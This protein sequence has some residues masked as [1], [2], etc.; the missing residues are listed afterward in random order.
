MTENNKKMKRSI[1][2][3]RRIAAA[4]ALLLLLSGLTSCTDNGDHALPAPRHSHTVELALKLSVS[5]ETD[6]TPSESGLSTGTRAVDDPDTA[7]WSTVKNVWILQFD[8]QDDSALLTGTPAYI[9]GY[10]T[11][12]DYERVCTLVNGTG[13]TVWI[14]AN[15]FDKDRIWSTDLTLGQLKTYHIQVDA[16]ADLHGRGEAVDID[17]GYPGDYDYHLLMNGTYTGNIDAGAELQCTL[18]RNAVRLD[19]CLKNLS[20][21]ITVDSVKLHRVIQR[22]FLYNS[23]ALPTVFPIGGQ[24]AVRDFEPVAFNKGADLGNGYTRFRFYLT[25]N[26]RGVNANVNDVWDRNRLAPAGATAIRVYARQTDGATAT[27]LT[28]TYYPGANLTT[29]FNLCPDHSYTCNAVIN[30]DPTDPHMQ[31][32]DIR[33][34]AAPGEERANCYMLNPNPAG[35]RQFRIPVDRINLFWGGRGYENAPGNVIHAADEWTAGVVWADFTPQDTDPAG[36]DYFRLVKPSGKGSEGNIDGYFTV[37]AGPATEGN[38]LVAVAKSGGTLWS[39]HL[40]ITGYDPYEGVLSG[41]LDAVQVPGGVYMRGN[42][43]ATLPNGRYQGVMDRPLG[44]RTPAVRPP[45]AYQF[46]R[47]DPFCMLPDNTWQYTSSAGY[48]TDAEAVQNPTVAIYTTYTDPEGSYWYS[49]AVSEWK[50][51]QRSY[52]T[53]MEWND[54]NTVYGYVEGATKSLFDP[55]PPGWKVPRTGIGSWVATTSHSSLIQLPTDAGVVQFYGLHSGH[56]ANYPGYTNTGWTARQGLRLR[57]ANDAS[58]HNPCIL[59][60]PTN[61]GYNGVPGINTAYSLWSTSAG[62]G[63]LVPVLAQR[64]TH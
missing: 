11:K 29:D 23:Y 21:D 40:W 1:S 45:L 28:F 42:G 60:Q 55:C 49:S 46:G 19:F 12:S 13:Q 36:A 8:G 44:S 63:G 35:T 34:F 50:P 18:Y 15:S 53:R 58:S 27:Q 10:D 56:G 16:E 41:E 31:I 3:G 9:A 5:Q 47:K 38:V 51:G 33:D 32:M 64:M 57:K 39:W 22:Q 48:Y 25:A 37:E 6:A 59:G 2:A 62:P 52:D 24:E 20:A 7:P 43:C 54:P 30:G 14:L 26:M 61:M 4:P 17:A